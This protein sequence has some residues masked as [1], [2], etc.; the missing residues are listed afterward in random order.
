MSSRFVQINA[1]LLCKGFY[2]TIIKQENYTIWFSYWKENEKIK[3]EFVVADDDSIRLRLYS[4]TANTA[5]YC[6]VSES[7]IKWCY[8][9][10]LMELLGM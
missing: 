7:E 5:D 9:E 3:V 2:K 10:D 6:C 8:L 4:K 1:I